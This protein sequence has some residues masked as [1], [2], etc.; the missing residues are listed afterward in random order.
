MAR[1]FAFETPGSGLRDTTI[2]LTT[3]TALASGETI[4]FRNLAYKRTT[5][6][7][8]NLTGVNAFDSII[9]AD[10]SLLI[11][12]KL[13]TTISVNTKWNIPVESGFGYWSAMK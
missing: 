10:S 4:N 12:H 9:V 3:Y 7:R 11:A 5:D 2:T 6:L 1:V 8:F 13:A